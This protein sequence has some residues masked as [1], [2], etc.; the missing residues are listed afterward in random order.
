[1][2]DVMA[3]NA[4]VIDIDTQ[5]YTRQHIPIGEMNDPASRPAVENF[6][7]KHDM[8]LSLAII[9]IGKTEQET[10]ERI[11]S[12]EAYLESY[13]KHALHTVGIPLSPRG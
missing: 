13:L 1:M 9:L 8:P 5:Q 12:M 4:P 7:I 3:Y 10:D 2:E 6:A 11:R